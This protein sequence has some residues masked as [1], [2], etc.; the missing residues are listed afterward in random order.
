VTRKHDLLDTSTGRRFVIR[1]G[2]TASEI[3]AGMA[4]AFGN[5]DA[6]SRKAIRQ[7]LREA[8]RPKKKSQRLHDAAACILVVSSDGNPPR[9]SKASIHQWVSETYPEVGRYLSYD[10]PSNVTIQLGGV[11]ATTISGELSP[12]A[13]PLDSEDRARLIRELRR[14][15]AETKQGELAKKEAVSRKKSAYGRKG[16]RGNEATD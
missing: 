12:D 14:A 11:H 2:M 9:Y 15:A 1:N 3:A 8:V 16:G 7:R 6:D 4:E 13:M 5:G 10:A